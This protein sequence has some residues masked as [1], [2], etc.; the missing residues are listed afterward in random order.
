MWGTLLSWLGGPVVN[1]LI[2][3][4]EKKLDAA[5][6]AGAQAVEVAKAAMVA[7]E[8][9]RAEA[10]KV[11]IAEQG[12]WYTALPRVVVQVSAALFFAKC[13][14]WDTVLGWGS[15]E[16]LRGDI[17]TT[18]TMV[19]AFWFGAAGI[20]RVMATARSWWK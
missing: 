8:Q 9:A 4:Y 6:Q 18:Y 1:G 20:S 5:N 17:Q 14:V 13:V 12:H 10:N 16:P 7:E 3:A 19:M 15:T 11:L 2:T